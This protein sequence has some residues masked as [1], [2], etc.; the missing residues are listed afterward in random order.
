MNVI[1]LRNLVPKFG[2]GGKMSIQEKT[3]KKNGKL[4]KYYYPVVSTY[5]L[6]KNKTPVWGPGFLKKEDAKKEE[7]KMLLNLEKLVSNNSKNKN[8]VLF[9]DIKDSWLKTRVT[10]EANTSE[11]DNDYCNIY[12]GVFD[13]MNVHE[14]N[15]IALQNWVTLLSSKYASKTVN[16]AFNLMSQIMDYAVSPLNILKENPCKHNIQRPKIKKRGIESDKYW[17]EEELIYFTT[18]PYTKEDPYYIMY[19][20]QVTLGLRPGEVCGLSIYDFNN[21]TN[22]LTLNH[23]LDKKNR[24][25]DLKNSGAQRTLKLPNSLIQLLNQ[26]VEFSN[27]LRPQNAKYPFLFVLDVNGSSINPDTYCQHLQRLIKRINKNSPDKQLKSIT[28]YGLRHTFAT[29]SISKGVHI[30]A[31][32]EAMGDSVETVMKNYAHILEQLTNDS[33]ELMA[34]IILSS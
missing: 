14:I 5:K 34:D 8:K 24:I 22:K 10:R 31:I 12:L 20:T 6:N 15:A 3:R 13:D 16:M 17:T 11:R 25:T 7:A 33:L 28:P 2:T 9:K 1:P 29:L 27:H 19:L 4:V 26:Q 18:H 32:A 21:N 23:G 30:K